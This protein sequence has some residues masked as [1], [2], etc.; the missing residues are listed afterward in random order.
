MPGLS[1]FPY[2]LREILLL[3]SYVLHSK[4]KPGGQLKLPSSAAC[5]DW[6]ISPL[7]NYIFTSILFPWFHSMPKLGCLETGT[8][9][10][11]G[12]KLRDLPAS[13]SGVLRLKTCITTP[14]FKL[15]F[16]SFSQVGNLAG[17]DLSL[18]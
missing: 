8:V 7:F 18:R 10:Q 6:N 13:S 9:D 5:W 16:N 15:F 17:W 11:A 3:F 4:A 14:S 2:S 1:G 12:L